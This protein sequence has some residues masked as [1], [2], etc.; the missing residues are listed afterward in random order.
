MLDVLAGDNWEKERN[1]W[2]S[3]VDVDWGN[4]EGKECWRILGTQLDWGGQYNVWFVMKLCF[5]IK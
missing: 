3:E 1:N 2:G 4:R 5:L